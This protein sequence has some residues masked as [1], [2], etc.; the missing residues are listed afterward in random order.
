MLCILF[1][2]IGILSREPRRT[3]CSVRVQYSKGLFTTHGT[4]FFIKQSGDIYLF[5]AAHNIIGDGKLELYTS[6][7]KQIHFA[8]KEKFLYKNLDI[9]VYRV[10]GDNLPIVRDCASVDIDRRLSS[11]GYPNAGDIQVFTGKVRR[12]TFS[13]T[14]KIESG[15]S[16]GPVFQNGKVVGI[17]IAKLNFNGK[18]FGVHVPIDVLLREI[19]D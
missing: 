13:S 1:L 10:E 3:F 11:S 17:T 8:I 2:S 15:M 6:E 18:H 4:G 7:R 14:C 16:G 19:S 9:V 5:T 12:V